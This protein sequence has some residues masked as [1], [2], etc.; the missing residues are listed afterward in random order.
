MALISMLFV[1]LGIAASVGLFDDIGPEGTACLRLAFAGL[2]LLVVVRPRLRAF[3]RAGL[4]ATLALGAVT[5]L[6]TMAY[7]AA[8]DRIPMGTASALEFLGPL[9]VA[10]LRGR[11]GTRAWP[12]VAAVGV[13]LLTEPWRGASDAVGV[14]FAL[15]AALAWALY[16]LLTQRVGDEVAG[17]QGL[18]VSMPVAGLIATLVAGPS[19]VGRLTPSILLAGLGLAI[20][21]PL[22]PFVLEMLTLRRLTASAFGTLMSLEPALALL[23]GLLVL[24]QS[25]G[26]LPVAGIAFV[27]VA[28]IGA[29]RGGAREPEAPSVALA[30]H[31]ELEPVRA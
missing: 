3:S 4:I 2:I 15:L 5:A 20:L 24:H 25:P 9:G 16:I 31:A 8:V 14:A 29:E 12:L 23:I 26:L 27:M 21:L 6:V 10:V 13:L 11:G 18:A 17:L 1:Q 30:E 7:M 19:I 28:V 22:V